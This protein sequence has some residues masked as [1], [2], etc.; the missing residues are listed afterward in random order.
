MEVGW[1]VFIFLENLKEI[2]FRVFMKIFRINPK[3]L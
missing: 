2:K 3:K 1:D